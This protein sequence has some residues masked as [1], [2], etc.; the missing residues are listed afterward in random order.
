[1]TLA[2][3]MEASLEILYTSDQSLTQDSICGTEDKHKKPSMPPVEIK[4]AN[5]EKTLSDLSL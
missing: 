3:F 4:R 5:S 2:T 1:M